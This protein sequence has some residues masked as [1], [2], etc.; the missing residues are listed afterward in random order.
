MDDNYECE[1][2]LQDYEI[3]EEGLFYDIDGNAY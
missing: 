1:S 3:N 2:I